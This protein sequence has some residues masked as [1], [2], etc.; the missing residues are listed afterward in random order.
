MYFIGGHFR[1]GNDVSE[2]LVDSGIVR[3]RVENLRLLVMPAKTG[4]AFHR[5]TLR[6]NHVLRYRPIAVAMLLPL[7][8]ALVVT[9]NARIYIGTKVAA[10]RLRELSAS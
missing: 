7:C 4:D 2:I 1:D 10:A 8:C 9:K 5:R 6:G 3:F